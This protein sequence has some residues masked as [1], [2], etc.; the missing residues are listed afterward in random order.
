[1][2]ISVVIPCR[3]EVQYIGECIQA[4]QN[5]EITSD[6]KLAVIID[7]GMSKDRTREELDLLQT[8]YTSWKVVDNTQQ[9]TPIAFNLGIYYCDFDFLQIIGARHIIMTYLFSKNLI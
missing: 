5:S 7:D 1:M 3:N 8:I 2:K 4:I 6:I 9:L